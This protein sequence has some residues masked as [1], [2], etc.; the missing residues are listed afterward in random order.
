M[1]VTTTCIQKNLATQFHSVS[2]TSSVLNEISFHNA[3]TLH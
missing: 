1:D 3:V 2:F